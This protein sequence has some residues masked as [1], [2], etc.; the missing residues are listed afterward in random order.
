[1]KIQ[2]STGITIGSVDY[3]EKDKI[4]TVL[5]LSGEK[6]S[7][8]ARGINSPKAK[9]KF[10]AQLFSLCEFEFTESRN[11]LLIS[12]IP[13]HMFW[14]VRESVEKLYLACFAI[15][16][17]SESVEDAKF[18]LA[19][20][21]YLEVN[22]Y[23]AKMA[24]KYI[25]EVIKHHG[26]GF[27]TKTCVNCG[28]KLIGK[29]AFDFDKSGFLCENCGGNEKTSLLKTLQLVADMSVESLAKIHFTKQQESEML[30]LLAAHYQSRVGR[31]SGNLR[32]IVKLGLGERIL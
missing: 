11:P 31:E 32:E 1:M 29:F 19:C 13:K 12:A 6:I 18:L 8:R 15:E 26:F 10:A 21:S 24:A 27:S 17:L 20:L 30:N 5:M 14:G 9:L 2:T 7:L 3:Q 28:G 4:V 22:E 16:N 23:S 25:F